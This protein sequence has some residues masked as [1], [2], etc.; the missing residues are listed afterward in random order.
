[1]CLY[2]NVCHQSSIYGLLAPTGGIRPPE[3][4]RS[5]TS[6]SLA[7]RE[8]IS[9]GVVTNYS[10]RRIVSQLGRSP[11]TISREIGCNGGL[12][13][14]RSAQAKQRAWDRARRPKSRNRKLRRTVEV[15]LRLNWSPEQVAGW[16]KKTYPEDKSN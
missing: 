8:E 14:Y 4:A 15:K 16:L 10:I 11:S 5:S 12:E 13:D 3:R 2:K 6:L 1:M 9:R 7:E